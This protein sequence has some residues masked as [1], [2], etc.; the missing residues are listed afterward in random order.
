MVHQRSVRD[1]N[2]EAEPQRS[3]CYGA[4][5]ESK[6]TSCDASMQSVVRVARIGP[7][8]SNWFHL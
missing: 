8:D 2:G 4:K 6:A 1:R 3:N 7:K 5:K